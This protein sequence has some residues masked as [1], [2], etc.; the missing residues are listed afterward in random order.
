MI[1]FNKIPLVLVACLALCLHCGVA[2]MTEGDGDEGEAGAEAS[3]DLR[4]I[5]GSFTDGSTVSSLSKSAKKSIEEGCEVDQVLAMDEEGRSYTGTFNTDCS[6]SLTVKV[7]ISY[8]ISF[9][10]GGEFIAT[11]TFNRTASSFLPVMPDPLPLD[12]GRISRVGSQ[13]LCND[14]EGVLCPIDSDGDGIG[15]CDDADEQPSAGMD[16]ADEADSNDGA[17]ASFCDDGRKVSICHRP[18]G[19]P[20]NAETIC[21]D[22]HSVTYVAHL[23]HGDTVGA[24]YDDDEAEEEEEENSGE[25][26]ADES[27]E[28][29]EEGEEDEESC[30]EPVMA[31]FNFIKFA[32]WNGGDLEPL[33]FVGVEEE[34]YENG[35]W[36]EVTDESGHPVIDEEVIMD[37]PG[38]AF[39]RGDGWVRFF[40]WGD[41]SPRLG[42]EALIGEL[43]FDGATIVKTAN[44]FPGPFEAQ[45]DGYGLFGRA[46]QD[47]YSAHGEDGVTVISTVTV[48][49]DSFT[50]FYR[51]D[52]APSAIRRSSGG[53]P[54]R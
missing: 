35:E 29:E 47:E 4:S 13:A 23:K 41:H 25:D 5:T 9:L 17:D 20:E 15:L 32:N 30:V 31:K 52:S 28:E 36:F 1:H 53:R 45:G 38:I 14:E 22:L 43:V 42:K 48:H 16:D 11:I 6:F 44:G 18:P 51:A 54:C 33:V 39:R 40:F 26:D 37:V 27:Q 50:V 10:H 34:P 46:G 21:V 19:N 8:I 49:Y 24:C 3:S 2:P 12:L 7:G